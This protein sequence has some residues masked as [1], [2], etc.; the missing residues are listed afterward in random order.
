MFNNSQQCCVLN[1]TNCFISASNC[2]VAKN[3]VTCYYL[4]LMC[5]RY[6]SASKIPCSP[7]NRRSRYYG[8][9]WR[10]IRRYCSETPIY[11]KKSANKGVDKGLSAEVGEGQCLVGIWSGGWESLL[12]RFKPEPPVNTGGSAYSQTYLRVCFP[13][14]WKSSNI[15]V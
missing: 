14:R 15:Y 5:G 6:G 10:I 7:K 1:K 9:C 12:L 2:L 8:S 11:R 3:S 4:S 13:P